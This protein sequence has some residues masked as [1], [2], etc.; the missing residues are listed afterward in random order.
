MFKRSNIYKI[1]SSRKKSI[2]N[3]MNQDVPQLS[4]HCQ[5]MR[6]RSNDESQICRRTRN[7]FESS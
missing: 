5:V 4:G 7:D 1:M 2:S 3:E 6:C